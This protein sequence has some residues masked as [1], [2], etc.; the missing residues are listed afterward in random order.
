MRLVSIILTLCLLA[1]LTRAAEDFAAYAPEDAF[2]FVSAGDMGALREAWPATAPGKLWADPEIQKATADMRQEFWTKLD[3]AL[4]DA[5]LT[6]DDISKLLP[7]QLA[8]WAESLDEYKPNEY[9]FV[10][11]AERTGDASKYV[12]LI[13]KIVAETIE[14]EVQRAKE[15]QAGLDVYTIRW[16]VAPTL[17]PAEQNTPVAQFTK[18][19]ILYAFPEGRLVVVWDGDESIERMM[20]RKDGGNGSLAAAEDFHSMA[21]AF[22]PKQVRVYSPLG[23]TLRSFIDSVVNVIGEAP[24]IDF[25]AL[26]AYDIRS[27][28]YA[29]SFDEDAIHYQSQLRLEPNARGIARALTSVKAFDPSLMRA[30]PAEPI[31]FSAS[32]VDMAGALTELI[33]AVRLASTEGAGLIGMI[34]SQANM[35]LGVSVE[36]E[37]IPALGDQLVNFVARPVEAGDDPNQITVM[38]L[39]SAEPIRKALT[40]FKTQIAPGAIGDGESFLGYTVYDVRDPSGEDAEASG[41]SLYCFALNESQIVFGEDGALVR[42]T[43]RRLAGKDTNNYFDSGK[44]T[45]PSGPSGA[46]LTSASRTDLGAFAAAVAGMARQ[47]MAFAAEMAKAYGGEAGPA[48]EIP[49]D[50]IF[51][52]YLGEANNCVWKTPDGLLGEGSFPNTPQR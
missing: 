45:P 25:E 42:E 17:T 16:D 24:P 44:F 20:R 3:P 43:L 36:A 27:L 51:E 23:S 29:I 5:G 22:G 52:R 50:E 31:S 9:G 12:E 26:G 6:R 14:V 2:F 34:F 18:H 8:F 15:T 13:D 32:G 4:E 37:L 7:G 47:R 19:S 21:S 39:K 1:P 40:G 41:E 33:K 49:G 30:V 10:L 38:T 11:M 28:G 48:P 35:Q 46:T